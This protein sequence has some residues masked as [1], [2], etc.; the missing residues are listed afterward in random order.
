[1]KC[2]NTDDAG[3]TYMWNDGCLN[4]IIRLLEKKGGS[5]GFHPS[6]STIN[7]N[8]QFEKELK[9]YRLQ[10]K[11]GTDNGRNH[12]LLFNTNSYYQWI[13]GG[14]AHISN[15]GFHRINGFRCGIGG[16][17][18]IF[19]IYKREELALMEEPFHIMDVAVM[20]SYQRMMDSWEDIKE[21]I[22]N[23]KRY[24]CTLLLNWHIIVFFSLRTMLDSFKLVNKVLEY[25]YETKD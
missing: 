21:V 13:K 25:S 9:R 7:N 10:Y 3:A 14:F 16:A 2:C 4:S 15:G 20:K 22:D 24:N 23:A 11:N 6:E 17:F 5:I 8:A 18:P 12:T 1:M 19:D